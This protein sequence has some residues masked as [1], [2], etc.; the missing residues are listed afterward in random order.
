MKRKES[1]ES[2]RSIKVPVLSAIA[3]AVFA[4]ALSGCAIVSTT[5]GG[6]LANV[7]TPDLYK[8]A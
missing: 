1:K 5:D 4:A 2:G 3:A 6:N 8:G 7:E